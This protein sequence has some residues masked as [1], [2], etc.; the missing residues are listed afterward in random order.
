[1]AKYIFRRTG[2]DPTQLAWDIEDQTDLRIGGSGSDGLHTIEGYINTSGDT[3]QVVLYEE[4]SIPTAPEGLSFRARTLNHLEEEHLREV[5]MNHVARPMIYHGGM[6]PVVTRY[7]WSVARILVKNSQTGDEKFATGF[8]FESR[9]M[10]LTASHVVTLPF[11]IQRIEFGNMSIG[12]EVVRNDVKRDIALLR[13]DREIQAPSLRIRR[14]IRAPDDL[15]MECVVVG[16]PNIPGMESSPSIYELRL[17]SI[18]KNYLMGQDVIELS[19]YLGSGC[20]GA[21]VLNARHSLIGMVVGYPDEQRG[22]HDAGRGYPWP[23]WTAVAVPCNELVG[24]RPT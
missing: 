17:A 19:T 3:V 6:A 13:L 9:D 21:P 15:G 22:D 18:R 5:V 1:M 14:A 16:F 20:S 23:K 12:G 4:G 7:A 24:W 8:L 2:H 11:V 10:F